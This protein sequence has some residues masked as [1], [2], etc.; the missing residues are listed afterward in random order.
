MVIFV[1]VK[2]IC[3]RRFYGTHSTY[4]IRTNNIKFSNFCYVILFLL[5]D[6]LLFYLINMDSLLKIPYDIKRNPMHNVR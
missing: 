3:E 2:L 5:K 4:L 6:M 1:H